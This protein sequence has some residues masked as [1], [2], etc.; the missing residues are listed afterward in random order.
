MTE[1]LTGGTSALKE[2]EA[3]IVVDMRQIDKVYP[4]GVIANN[5]VDFTLRE[6]E[7]HALMGENGAGKTTLMKILFGIEQASAGE[8]YLNGEQVSITSPIKAIN[9]GIGMVHQHFMLVPSLTVTENIILGMEPKSKGLINYAEAKRKVSEVMER[10]NFVVDPNARIKDLSVGK[11]QK[12]EILKALYRGAKILILDEPTAVLTPQETDELFAELKGLSKSG[13]SIVFI[14]HKIN[15]IKAI[16]EKI[17]IMRLGRMVDVQN[18]KDMTAQQISTAM[19]GRDVITKIDKAPLKEGAVVVEV[20][21]LIYK[22]DEDKEVVKNISMKIKGGKILGI[23]GVEGNGQREFIDCLTGLSHGYSGEIKMNGE[24]IKDKS[25]KQIRRLGLAHIPEDR[26]KYGAAL[27]ENIADNLISDRY[28]SKEY[29]SGFLQKTAKITENAKAMIE[30]F[31]IVTDSEKT[32]ARMLSGGNIQKVVAAREMTSEL[33][34]L[35]ADQPTRG[36]DVGAATFVHKML[37]KLRDEG[38]AVLLVSA[39]MNEVMELSDSLAVFYEGEISG[40]FED[41]C[42]VTEEELGLYMLGLKKMSEDELKGVI[43]DV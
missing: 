27:H 38:K 2:S 33:E 35:V 24:T 8:I 30:Q 10:Y 7:I 12:V 42:S 3:K 18:V 25:I 43:G 29:N 32:E 4:N 21:N 40:Y 17:S 14:S 5:K 41:A 39:D 26:M 37:V 23:A 28:D 9:M 20:S 15:E 36:I 6:G 22:N 34:I 31:Q 19:V 1:H 16:C 13:H 11:K